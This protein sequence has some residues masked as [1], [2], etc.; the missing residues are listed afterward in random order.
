MVQAPEVPARRRHRR[1]VARHGL[2]PN[3]LLPALPH[4][5]AHRHVLHRF[6][7]VCRRRRPHLGRLPDDGRGGGAGGFQ[8]DVPPLRPRRPS[9]RR[10]LAVV[11]PGQAPATGHSQGAV[12][13][14]EVVAPEPRRSQGR[15]CRRT[16]PRAPPGVPPEALDTQGPGVRAPRLAAVAPALDVLW[17]R[18]CRHRYPALWKHH[19]SVHQPRVHG[20]PDQPALRPH[21]DRKSPSP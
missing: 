19:N 3:L 2:L 18:G 13:P 14:D 20:R 12:W 16:L 15:G 10:R 9:G 21:L 6:A 8:V 1:H 17:C 4:R 5:Q 11:A 7:A